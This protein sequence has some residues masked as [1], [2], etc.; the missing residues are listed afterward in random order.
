MKNT[1]SS[2]TPKLT[3]IKIVRPAKIPDYFETE[4]GCAEVESEENN[5]SFRMMTGA[6]KRFHIIFYALA[7]T[8]GMLVVQVIWQIAVLTAR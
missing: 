4:V 7:V 5:G 3:D 1:L 8:T 2:E 6:Q